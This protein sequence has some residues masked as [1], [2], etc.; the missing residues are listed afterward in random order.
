MS[1]L[2]GRLN[3][4]KGMGLSGRT[5]RLP[6]TLRVYPASF[7]EVEGDELRISNPGQETTI[8]A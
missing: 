6:L 8:L 2:L 3:Y 5:F 4:E 7:G 1:S